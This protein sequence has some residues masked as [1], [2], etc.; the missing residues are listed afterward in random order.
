[1]IILVINLLN[2]LKEIIFLKNE[3][4]LLIDVRIISYFEILIALTEKVTLKHK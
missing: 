3:K 4:Q 1:M 2:D